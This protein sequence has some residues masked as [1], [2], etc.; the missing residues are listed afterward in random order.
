MRFLIVDDDPQKLLLVSTFLT[1]HGI[2]PN[3]ILQAEHAAAARIAL[4]NGSVDVLLIDV[5]LPARLGAPARGQNCVELLRQ[6]MEDGTTPAPRYIIGMT[7]NADTRAEF[8]ADFESLVTRVLHIAP[9]EHRWKQ[10]LSGYLL[11]LR[12]TSSARESNDFDICVLNALREPELSGL[13]RAWGPRL[14][15]EQ[16]LGRSISYRTGTVTLGGVERRLVCAHL[17]QMG[18]VASTHA[19]TA[20]LSEFRPRILLM[21]GICGGFADHVDIGDLVVAEKS[22][23]WQA[24]KWRDG[25][26]APTEL[27]AA[28]VTTNATNHGFDA[29]LETSLDQRNA[30]PELIAEAQALSEKI[31]AIHEGYQG[32]KPN[33]TPKLVIGP[34]VTGSSVVASTDIQTLFREQHR[35]MIGV[36]MEC[37]GVYYA[38][39]LHGGA[40]V[41]AICIKSVSDLAD[42]AKGDDFQAYCSHMSAMIA[43][44]TLKGYFRR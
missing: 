39:E 12:Y 23:D 29:R 43:L 7:A 8:E 34:M 15:A 33:K 18:P 6:I 38:A 30:S 44:E 31:A 22:W 13:L 24:G 35:K 9:G 26:G 11:Y 28:N 4:S 10:D 3:D 27:Q 17:K 16:L 36:D 14:G 1:E 19:A 37:Y 20:M 2:S 32:V 5:L 42:R 40:P 21:T 25:G 41:K